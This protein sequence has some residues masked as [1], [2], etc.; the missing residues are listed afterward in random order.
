MTHTLRPMPTASNGWRWGERL[1][2]IVGL[3]ILVH[4]VFRSDYY[5]TVDGPSHAYTSSLMIAPQAASASHAWEVTPLPVPNWT[6]HA[7]LALLQLLGFTPI[8]ALKLLHAITLL[9][10]P[11]AVRALAIYRGARVPWASALAIP[12]AVS[13]MFSMG[14]YNFCLGASVF[15]GVVWAWDRT[16]RKGVRHWL[17]LS[18][19][20]LL[21]YFTHMLPF[22][23]ALAY[24]AVQALQELIHAL[25]RATG[26]LRSALIRT[27]HLAAAALPSLVLLGWYMLGTPE[28]MSLG[29]G[30]SDRWKIWTPYT[31]DGKDGEYILWGAWAMCVALLIAIRPTLGRADVAFS[32]VTVLLVMFIPDGLGQGSDAVPRMMILAHVWILVVIPFTNAGHQVG[33]WF[34]LASIGIMIGFQAVRCEQHGTMENRLRHSTELAATVPS[35]STVATVHINWW[36]PHL[37]ELGLAGRGIVHLSNYELQHHHFPLRWKPEVKVRMEHTAPDPLDALSGMT[38]LRGATLR[39]ADYILIAGEPT[40][41]EQRE[42][43]QLLYAELTGTHRSGPSGSGLALLV[44]RPS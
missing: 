11:L 7:L 41:E 36:E 22:A 40:N 8:I 32:L 27:G 21:S 15:L 38:R 10:F 26:A 24:L 16:R 43:L 9:S 20:L 39:E 4:P 35:G 25:L 42:R 2:F 19:L 34:S 33:A 37:F 30:G 29:G 44:R 17:L 12:L 13:S 23:F 28:T 18:F 6:G 5:F 1:L 14:F 31:F 3:C